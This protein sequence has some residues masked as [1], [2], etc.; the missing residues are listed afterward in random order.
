MEV[1]G[2]MDSLRRHPVMGSPSKMMPGV[3]R[4]AVEDHDALGP[5]RSAS[6]GTCGLTRGI[7]GGLGQSV[8]G[9]GLSE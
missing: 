2:C 1:T 4:R 9:M 5:S 6:E 3:Q 8:E 7:A